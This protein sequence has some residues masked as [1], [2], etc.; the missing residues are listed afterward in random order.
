[1]F[2]NNE[3]KDVGIY[4]GWRLQLVN[5]NKPYYMAYFLKSPTKAP[6]MMH[7]TN[8]E[9]LKKQIAGSNLRKGV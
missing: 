7:N 1:M 2:S 6:I 5:G 9:K 8:L 3:K 4:K